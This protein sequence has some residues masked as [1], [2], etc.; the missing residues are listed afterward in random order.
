M[1]NSLTKHAEYA[2]ADYLVPDTNLNLNSLSPIKEA[3]DVSK[4]QESKKSLYPYNP[5]AVMQTITLVVAVIL[6]ASGLIV[7]PALILNA[8]E[9]TENNPSGTSSVH[10]NSNR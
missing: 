3:K 6:I 4:V 8:Q 9:H 10:E 2:P 7:A 5:D 1:K